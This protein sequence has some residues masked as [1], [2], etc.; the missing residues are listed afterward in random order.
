M[1]F[2]FM[3]FAF[4]FVSTQLCTSGVDSYC[5]SCGT[6]TCIRC[7]NS[8]PNSAG[9]CTVPS[10]RVNYCASYSS[11]TTCAECVEGYYLTGNSCKSLP[12]NCAVG[13][14][15]N[16]C[17]FCKSGYVLQ[18]NSCVS[19]TCA[20]PN[21]ARCGAISCAYCINGWVLGTGG[22]CTTGTGNLL[23]CAIINTT[24]NGCGMCMNGYYISSTGGCIASSNATAGAKALGAALSIILGLLLSL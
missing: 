10:S 23:N 24:N 9:V 19:G 12:S 16:V 20:Q 7:V 15:S 13:T 22:V 17:T 5:S 4:G 2:V 11:A 21:C 3:A 14:G 18:N 6:S 1:N 8:Y